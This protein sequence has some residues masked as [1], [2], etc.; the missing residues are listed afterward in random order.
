MAELEELLQN[1]SS[2]SKSEIDRCNYDRVSSLAEILQTIKYHMASL[3]SQP[4]PETIQKA[5]QFLE[6]Y[7]DCYKD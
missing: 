4:Q 3:E 6:R 5:R 7:R 1:Y 2:L